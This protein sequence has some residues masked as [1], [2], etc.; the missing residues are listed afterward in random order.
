MIL[1]AVVLVSWLVLTLPAAVL[2]GK[3]IARGLDRAPQGAAT[4]VP[5]QRTAPTHEGGRSRA[6]AGRS[7]A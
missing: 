1:L 3:C 4:D 6:H 2:M 5:S 7:Q